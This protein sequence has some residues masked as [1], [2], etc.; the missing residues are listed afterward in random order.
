MKTFKILVVFDSAGTPPEDQDFTQEFKKEEWLTE[1]V[2]VQTLREM[3][4]EVRT[5][6]I[7]DDIRVL[8]NELDQNRPDVV[9][10]LT[11]LFMGKA[12]LDKNIPAFLDLMEIPYTGCGPDGLVL[13]NHK[14]LSKKILTYHRIKVP[15]FHAFRKGRRVCRAVGAMHSRQCSRR[16]STDL[17]EGGS[18]GH[19]RL[20]RILWAPSP[21][22]PSER[23]RQP[24]RPG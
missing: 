18:S 22:K 9:F 15:R 23:C 7:Y 10:N 5:L 4:H 2:V 6:G 19:G 12:H 1:T 13:C 3:G 14:A 16:V 8:I 11:E 24:R 20:A 21:S 17:S